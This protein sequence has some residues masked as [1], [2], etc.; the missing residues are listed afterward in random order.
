M[1][2]KL[3]QINKLRKLQK[4]LGREKMDVEKNGVVVT[5]NG[6]IEIVNIK[7][8]P[9]LDTSGQEKAIR[10][11]VNDAV[12]KIQYVAAQR[13]QEFGSLGDFGL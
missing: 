6:N 2:G 9:N 10:D 12:K 1:L 4:E 13:M 8:N 7:L 3:K 5:I 11:C